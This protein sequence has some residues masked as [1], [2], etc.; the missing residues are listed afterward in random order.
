[1]FDISS[2]TLLLREGKQIRARWDQP[3]G[4]KIQL[5]TA[6]DEL[7]TDW[8]ALNRKGDLDSKVRSE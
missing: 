4:W 7:A 6:I 5:T 3:E 2:Y 1:M 8:G